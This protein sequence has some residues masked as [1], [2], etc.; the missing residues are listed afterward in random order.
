M[1][2]S[3]SCVELKVVSHTDVAI[4]LMLLT[5]L[6]PEKLERLTSEMPMI[7][8]TLNINNL[9]GLNASS[10]WLCCFGLSIEIIAM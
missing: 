6:V 9:K 4:Y 7:T 10:F 1:V 2:P 3:Q 5:L 8:Q